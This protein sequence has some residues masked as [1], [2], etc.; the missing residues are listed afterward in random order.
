MAQVLFYE[1][2]GCIN[3]TRQK[4]IL[5][6]AGHTVVAM[7]LLTE[8]WATKENELRSF[9]ADKPVHEW[10]NRSAPAIK[11]GIIDPKKVTAEQAISLMQSDPLLIR[12]PLMQSGNQRMAGFNEQEVMRW[13][14]L[15]TVS[16]A[17]DAEICSKHHLTPCSHG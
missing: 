15:A 5:R 8:N 3:N 11:Q 4:E 7:N 12:R 10:F 17:S 9:F 16:I 13:L 14:G 6:Q 2:P 1:K